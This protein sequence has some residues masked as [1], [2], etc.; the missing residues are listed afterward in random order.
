MEVCVPTHFL[1]YEI[2]VNVVLAVVSL[3]AIVHV[4]FQISILNGIFLVRG[5]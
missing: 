5:M 3:V 1:D 2:S 4:L